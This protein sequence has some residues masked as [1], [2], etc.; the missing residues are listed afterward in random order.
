M[1][2]DPGALKAEILKITDPGDPGWTAF[3]ATP[4]EVA[5]RWTGA[6]AV[7][8]SGMAI[9]AAPP[10]ALAAGLGACR[11]AMEPLVDYRLPFTDALSAGLRALVLV[12]AAQIP[13]V[14]PT[15]PPPGS[16]SWPPLEP[17]AD[18]EP[19]AR[20]LAQAID[21]WMRTGVV[22]LGGVTAVP[23]S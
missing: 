20:D 14:N 16:P 6:I 2:L 17:S 15:I 8:L 13:P 5:E 7:Y 9:P 18:P 1:P 23:W 19:P 11:S 12:L 22:V 3:P 4:A 21:L 10:S